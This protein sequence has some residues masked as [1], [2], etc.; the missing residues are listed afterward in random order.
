V[1]KEIQVDTIEKKNT[2]TIQMI[3]MIGICW[4]LNE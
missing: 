2:I 4:R 3:Y 1:S